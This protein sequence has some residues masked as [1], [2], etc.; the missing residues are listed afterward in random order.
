MRCTS[1]HT[2]CH[3]SQESLENL[4]QRVSESERVSERERMEPT[5]E[6]EKTRISHIFATPL[7]SVSLFLPLVFFSLLDL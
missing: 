6:A 1:C 3:D 4:R 7:F 5:L 2:V